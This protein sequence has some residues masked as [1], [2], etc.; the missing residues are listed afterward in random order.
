MPS[1]ILALALV[2]LLGACA[3]TAIPIGS[4]PRPAT[5]GARPTPPPQSSPVQRPPTPGFIAPRVMDAPGLEGV[6]GADAEALQRTFGTARLNVWEGD[7]R[8]L[9]FG[10][11]AC[12]LDVY[13]Y[14]LKK[15][16]EP[17]ATYVDARRSSDGL[18]VDRAACV[19]ALKER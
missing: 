19:R 11:E 3:Q 16:A 17:T 2:P 5:Q 7:A 13:L 8:K 1:R 14:P 15:G 6:I 9:Q 10:G 18:D 12:V 4:A